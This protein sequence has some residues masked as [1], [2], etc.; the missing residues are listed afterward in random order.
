MRSL[1]G[2]M[3]RFRNDRR[4]NVAVIFAIACVPLISAIGCALDYSEATRIKAKMQS[5]ADAAAVA[6]ISQN[7][8]GWLASTAQTSNGPVTVAETDAV[9]VFNGNVTA[10]SSLYNGL[11][12]T[13]TVTKTGP[14]LASI[15]SFSANVPVTFMKVVGWSQLTVTGSSSATSS[16]P[17]YL[18]FY[19]M[20]DV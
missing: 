18:D 11:V 6:A 9:N 13:A 15:V 10:Q 4:A 14:S 20:L 8:A 5:A 12:V 2:L 16:L 3:N 1:F 19:V 7:S 17:L